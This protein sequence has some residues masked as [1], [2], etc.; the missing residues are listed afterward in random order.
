MQGMLFK[1]ADPFAFEC[2]ENELRLHASYCESDECPEL[3]ETI[4]RNLPEARV[5]RRCS[6]NEARC[7][8]YFFRHD[9]KG[10]LRT[11]I[12]ERYAGWDVFL[13]D[14]IDG[15]PVSVEMLTDER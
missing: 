6:C 10:N 1:D 7:R 8:T 11:L 4:R 15:C 12:F 9:R 13:I 5:E 2:F 3:A 14:H